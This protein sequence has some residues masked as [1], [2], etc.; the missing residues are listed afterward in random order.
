MLKMRKLVR[1]MLTGGKKKGPAK[2]AFAGVAPYWE[3]RYAEGGASG[4]GS[5]GRLAEF[6]AQVLNEFVQQHPIQTI[7]ELGCGD[8][9]QLALARYPSYVGVDLSSTAVERCRRLFASDPTKCFFHASERDGYAGTYDLV[10]S[11]D[12]I[13]HLVEDE[14]YKRYMSDL[15]RYAGKY[16]I[17]YSSNYDDD[18]ERPWALHVRHRK[19]SDDFDRLPEQWVLLKKID[20]PYAFD[21]EDKENT[22]FADFY[23][24]E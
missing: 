9:S 10:L 5:I 8:G 24:Y 16:I 7:L 14:V 3:K 13:F 20:N 19:F 6:K 22:T 2:A 4:A 1:R 21:P 11:L 17:V 12:V 23:F 18:P 15:Q